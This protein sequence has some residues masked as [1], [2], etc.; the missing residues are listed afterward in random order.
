MERLRQ[1]IRFALRSLRRSPGH[2]AAALLALALGIGA[3]AA[4]FSVVYGVL[5]EPLPY[6]S[7]ERLVMLID[8]NPTRGFDRFSS[9][10]PNFVDWRDQSRSFSGMAALT[11]A[12][13]SLT[14]GG[15]E[16]ERLEGAQVSAGFFETL[17][18]PPA[19]GRGIGAADD[20]P[21]APKVA[22]LSHGLWRRRF[23]ADPAIVGRAVELDGS[24]HTVVGIAAEGFQFPSRV[25]VWQ[26]LALEITP[27]M[28][29]AHFVGVAARLKPGVS[30]E[31]AQAE[32][33]VIA[34]RLEKQYPDS[35]T[36]W[37]VNVIPT[38]E[39]VVEDV[40][41]ALLVLMATVAVVLL[42]ACANVAN[43]LLARMAS[44]ER[45]VAIRTA[46]GAGRGRLIRQFLTESVLLALA[47]GALGLLL[48]LWGVRALVAMNADNIPRAAEIGLEPPVLL[49]T[50]ALAVLTGL[51]FGL[52]PAL[53][54]AR[55]DLQGSLKEGGRGAGT[56]VR[57]RSARGALVVV[58][59]ALTLVLLVSAGLLLRSFAG[60]SGVSPGF[61][62]AGV[63]TLEV[64]LPESRYPD[65]EEEG[66]SSKVA[67]FYDQ[68]LADV[69]AIPGVRSAG[70]GYPLPLGGSGFVLA[71]VVEGRPEPPPGQEP[72][73]HIRFVTP[74][75]LETMSIPLLRG[76]RLLASDR[77]GA[78]PVM[79]VNR[80]MAE[81]TWP[82]EEAL[83]KRLTFGDPEDE[84]VEWRTVVGVVGD[85]R[86]EALAT[87]PA[88]E[89]YVP[90]GQAPSSAATLVVRTDGDPMRLAA[91]VREAVRRADPDLPVFAVLPLAEVVA[92]SLA[93]QRFRTILLALFAGLALVLA[94]VGVYGVISYGVTQRRHEMGLRMALGARRE[95]VQRL[96]VGQ[97]LR[98]V[99][100]GAAVGL[101]GA[102]LATRLLASF[103]YGV[104]ATD[105][106]T[107]AAVPALL[108]GVALF[109]SWLPARRA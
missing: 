42:I 106:L 92:Q 17:G 3:N 69:R 23:G 43:L 2:T 91:P 15:V 29:G 20:R 35:N 32:M 30:L 100:T 50:L 107:F 90:I 49:F 5:L 41:P 37:G 9:S 102:F 38:R 45:E 94:S 93:E 21:G 76:R 16:P 56:G 24:P 85:V 108:A 84:D 77:E 39:L 64:N 52:V 14:G 10:P 58:E 66:E 71:F 55:P 99:L 25:E 88:A 74:G 82:G 54:A 1:D 97:G 78:L 83:G 26:P 68:V 27:D 22:V 79:V 61:E 40:R 70:A 96:V 59:V 75:Y 6:P 81:K 11:R 36:G 80:T 47:G 103:L 98:L 104:R 86:H 89:T 18:V 33:S 13:P 44:R 4:I 62:T 48:A 73:S 105:P 63:L 53:H 28:R 51:V 109:A 19:L 95:Q 67:A 7:P 57:A 31:R 60:L 72:N 34:G 8:S 65:E 101:V 12:N 46:L 87:E